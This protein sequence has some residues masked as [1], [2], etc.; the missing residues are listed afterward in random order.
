MSL[1]T[2]GD[3]KLMNRSQVDTTYDII[4]EEHGISVCDNHFFELNQ[5]MSQIEQPYQS[6]LLPE[7]GQKKN[8]FNDIS[9]QNLDIAADF[10]DQDEEC[11]GGFNR[12]STMEIAARG[13]MDKG[14]IQFSLTGAAL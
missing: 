4:R 8:K 6:S 12:F 1:R 9:I 5:S 2:G 10:G 7:L 3:S 11:I 13:R 14:R